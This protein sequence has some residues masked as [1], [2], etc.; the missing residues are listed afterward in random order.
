RDTKKAPFEFLGSRPIVPPG[1][2]NII[3]PVGPWLKDVKKKGTMVEREDHTPKVRKGRGVPIHAKS[4]MI[5]SGT[6]FALFSLRFMKGKG[7]E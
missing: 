3:Q 7:A 6:S 5:S 1:R 2:T 4:L